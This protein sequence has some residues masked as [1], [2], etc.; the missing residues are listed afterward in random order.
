MKLVAKT[1]Q[2][3][4]LLSGAELRQDPSGE[5]IAGPLGGAVY[6]KH[7]RNGFFKS[8]MNTWS[9]PM[10]A[11]STMVFDGWFLNKNGSQ[12]VNAARGEPL[13]GS[14]WMSRYNAAITVVSNASPL[15]S[16]YVIIEQRTFDCVK[17]S[18][19]VVTVE[20]QAAASVTGAVIGVEFIFDEANGTSTI[21]SAGTLALTSKPETYRI[22][23]AMPPVS[24]TALGA[25]HNMK[26]RFW[27]YGGSN[28]TRRFGA[29]INNSVGVSFTFSGF[30]DG[31]QL[32]EPSALD[33]LLEVAKYFYV[34][35]HTQF[36]A[37]AGT[38]AFS[39][40]AISFTNFP[41][42]AAYVPAPSNI[43]VT[44]LNMNNPALTANQFGFSFIGTPTNA[45]SAAR[46]TGYTLNIE[47]PE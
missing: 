35:T 2:A 5:V 6:P 38:S 36:M 21:V 42:P 15:V 14:G 28:Y 22:Q 8:A 20:F 25:L 27:L 30:R 41:T 39:T 3:S 9:N 46:I 12:V 34:S 33:E 37:A 7:I 1:S 47:L 44:S 26:M 11:V 29:A 24:G 43:T 31:S 17:F 13:G 16:D 10:V 32:G 19:K 18:D 23:A 4:T 45:T 40:T